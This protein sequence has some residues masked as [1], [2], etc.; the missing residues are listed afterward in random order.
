MMEGKQL[1]PTDI[2]FTVSPLRKLQHTSADKWHT[3]FVSCRLLKEEQGGRDEDR[4]EEQPKQDGYARTESYNNKTNDS[5]KIVATF[6]Q[7]HH[8]KNSSNRGNSSYC[9]SNNKVTGFSFFPVKPNLFPFLSVRP[10][11]THHFST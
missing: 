7:L 3:F 6:K 11:S 10:L 4:T 1:R 5:M 9:Y 8:Y 2:W